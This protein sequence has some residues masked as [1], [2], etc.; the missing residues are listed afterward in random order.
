MANL[1]RRTFLKWSALTP[2]AGILAVSVKPSK[3]QIQVVDDG[4]V[5][6]NGW[7]LKRSDIDSALS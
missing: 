7:V 4:F 5:I 1:S 2:L 6:V 3:A